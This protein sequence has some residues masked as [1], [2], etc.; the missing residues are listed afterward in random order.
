MR[1]ALAY[2]NSEGEKLQTPESAQSTMT[3]WGYM[4]VANNKVDSNAK[5]ENTEVAK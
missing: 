3:A 1:K 4:E 5:V 2:K